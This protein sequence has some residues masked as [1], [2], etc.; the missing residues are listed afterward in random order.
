M[1]Q[2]PPGYEPDELPLLH[3]AASEVIIAHGFVFVKACADADIG[4]AR[5]CRGG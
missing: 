4:R 1:N 3:P 2:R 5:R